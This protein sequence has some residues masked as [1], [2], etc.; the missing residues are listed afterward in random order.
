MARIKN[1][2]MLAVGDGGEAWDGKKVLN[3]VIKEY[4]ANA[5]TINANTFVEFIEHFDTGSD[6]SI[7]TDSYSG[8]NFSA[9]ALD[10][11]KVFIAYSRGSNQQL[12][13]I[14]CEISGTIITK[15]SETLLLGT[16]NSF[17]KVTVLSDSKVFIS[18][19]NTLANYVYDLA[20][21]ISGKTITVGSS[22]TIIT[23]Y[24]NDASPTKLSSSKVLLSYRLNNT[25]NGVVCTVSGTTV[26]AG[27][28]TTL[29]TNR[30]IGFGGEAF[31]AVVAF[32]DVKAFMYYIYGNNATSST[33]TPLYLHG[34]TCTISGTTITSGSD[35]SIAETPSSNNGASMPNLA[36]A[37]VINDSDVFIAH[38]YPPSSL[39][40]VVCSTVG[41]DTIVGKAVALSTIAQ[42]GRYISVTTIDNSKVFIAHSYQSNYSLRGMACVINGT[43]ITQGTDVAIV[44]SANAGAAIS[45]T[46]LDSSKVFIAHQHPLSD[47]SIA[48][49]LYGIIYELPVTM[50][51]PTNSNNIA[52]L[53]KTECTENTP[54]E[55]W[56]LGSNDSN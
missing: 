40:G 44:P 11:S 54:G 55:V 1:P 13:C 31:T 19:L 17:G 29:K 10:D 32:S 18:V 20:C 56:V 53:T 2:Q 49:Y 51:S 48:K 14:V 3:G 27:T 30:P 5:G 46:L 6:T 43:T 25:V 22:T 42:S 37:A 38:N 52:G 50:V 8:T 39:Y 26:T 24:T 16:N 4:L 12:Y 41:T 15:G 36:S 35:V 21:T 23:Q 28:G 45:A 33:D 7:S 47:S 34:F 9:V